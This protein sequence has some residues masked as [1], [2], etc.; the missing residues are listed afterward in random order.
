MAQSATGRPFT[1]GE[2]AQLDED[3]LTLYGRRQLELSAVPLMPPLHVP[4]RPQLT[5]LNRVLARQRGMLVSAHQRSQ[6]LA[7]PER[8]LCGL[9]D[10][11]R[12]LAQLRAT[13]EA[14]A[15]G[16]P[17]EPFMAGLT[18]TGCLS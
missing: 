4:E 2:R 9:L 15:L 12:T 11:T 3:L 14:T 16:G 10:G 18:R 1:E 13:P 7:E 5:P 6:R 8:R 17:L